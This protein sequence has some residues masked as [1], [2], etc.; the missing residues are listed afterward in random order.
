M[1][2]FLTFL[3]AVGLTAALPL[4]GEGAW[5]AKGCGQSGRSS[6]MASK[7]NGGRS[8]QQR[9]M[10]VNSNAPVVRERIIIREV[11]PLSV[12]VAPR[13]K[14]TIIEE[15]EAPQ[16]ERFVERRVIIREA[17]PVFVREAAPVLALPVSDTALLIGR[18]GRVRGVVAP[19]V[20]VSVVAPVRFLPRRALLVV[21]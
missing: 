16:V 8:M 2:K 9:T 13:V 14:R 7:Y 10:M 19:A 6:A 18:R 4:F 11:A 5:G 21:P 20:G 3:S 15:E 12:P 1:K 17:A